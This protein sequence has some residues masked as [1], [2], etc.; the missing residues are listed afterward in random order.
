MKI[1]EI[2]CFDQGEIRVELMNSDGDVGNGRVNLVDEFASLQVDTLGTQ[3]VI[4]IVY[5]ER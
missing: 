3:P 5:G 2:T 1:C 4:E